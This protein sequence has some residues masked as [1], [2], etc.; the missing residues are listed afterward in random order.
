MENKK[1]DKRVRYTKMFIKDSFV[2]LLKDKPISKITIKEI[3]ENADI[4]RATFYAHYTDQY[5][6]LTQIENDVI[7]D[8][9]EYLSGE[10]I[11][12][13][14]DS[15]RKL[16]QI[17]TYIRKNDEICKI[18]LSDNA[19]A[20]FQ[21]LLMELVWQ[22]VVPGWAQS[23]ALSAEDMEYIYTFVFIGCVGIIKKWLDGGM[24]KSESEMAALVLR[25]SYKGMSDF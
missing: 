21:K 24:V 6:L 11:A 3:C 18:L 7:N 20:N 10:Y 25:L 4:N 12:D 23:K 16:S 13:D 19:D 8:V 5:D 9:H 14:P 15:I 2:A 17:F 1:Q 22:E